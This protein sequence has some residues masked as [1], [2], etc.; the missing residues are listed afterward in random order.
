MKVGFRSISFTAIILAA[1][2]AV[3]ER[4]S[5]DPSSKPVGLDAATVAFFQQHCV[6]C[7]GAKTAEAD[8]RLD[9]L[10]ADVDRR[11]VFIRWHTIV[12]RLRAGEMPPRDEPQPTAAEQTAAIDFL[13]AKLDAASQRR[14]ESGRVVLRRLNRVEYENT[15][16]DLFAVDVDIRE[17]LPEDAIALGFDNVGAAL[18]VSPMLMERYLE[19]IDAVLN[20]AVA[21]PPAVP[22]NKESHE[23][24]D[25]LPQYRKSVLQR[26]DDVVLF[27]NESPTLL[28]KWRARENGTYR[29]RIECEAY[30][31]DVPLT[32]QVLVGNFLTVA[33]SA[34]H[35]GFFDVHPRQQWVEVEARLNKRETI[36]V[37]PTSLPKVNLNVADFP[38]YPG[39]GLAVGTIECEGPLPQSHPTESYQR[40]YGDAD[41]KT[42]GLAD[43]E[44]IL[45]ALLPRAFR[46]PTTDADLAPFVKIVEQSLA[47]GDTFDEALRGGIKLVLCSPWFIYF[48]EQPGSL[49]D[50]ALASR[51]SYFLWSTMPDD[52]LLAVAGRGELK[53]PEVLRAQTERLLQDP[54]AERFIENFTGQWLSLRDIDFTTP[55]PQLYPEFDTLLRWS[56][57]EETR[58]FFAELLSRDLSVLNFIDSDFTFLNNRLAKHYGIPGVEGVALR[59]VTLMP[60]YHRGGVLAQAA[61]LKVTANGTTTSPVVRGVWVGDRI[62]GRP[63][64][65]PPPNVP[66]IEPNIRGATTVREQLAKHRQIDSCA[67]C[68]SKI[69]P[70]GFALESY[71]VIGG[72]RKKYRAVGTKERAK[73]P[74]TN[75]DKWLA[76]P[77]YGFGPAVDA[78]DV[79]PD[80]RKFADLAEFKKLLAADPDQTARTVAEKLLIY[81]TGG[82][83]EYGDRDELERIVAASRESKYG[84]RSLVHEVVQSELFLTK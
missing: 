68:H 20:A 67:G 70:P 57:L 43:A 71:D 18:N 22:S 65:P 62:L 13:H 63:V 78:G 21:Q 69:D 40:V 24:V 45:R 48:D 26:K 79:L 15:L 54:R 49:D 30:Q 10:D 2:L 81:A 36:K 76:K 53:K 5:A 14:K 52:E 64:P 66:A 55:D 82:G 6:R 23:L 50:Y 61:V 39:I 46:R 38:H 1:Q 73:F 31:S 11:E 4:A 33:G 44:K 80:G 75:I 41:P 25:S 9:R 27:R 28:G 51:L 12:E 72:Y 35:V 32:M 58:R 84:L 59:K 29:F 34:R 3:V 83:L 16:R 37:L 17:M 60:E 74:P 47:E 77:G 7:H 19:A 42:A 56:M 8:L